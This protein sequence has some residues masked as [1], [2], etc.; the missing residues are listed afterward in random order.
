MN[1]Y[2]GTI[3]CSS[4]LYHHGIKGQKWGVRRFQNKDGS[5]IHRRA[6]ISR[7]L[8]KHGGKGEPSRYRRGAAVY[9][10]YN[11]LRNKEHE[12]LTKNSKK[13]RETEKEIE[14]L[15]NKWAYDDEEQRRI[16]DRKW[17]KELERDK[18]NEEFLKKAEKYATDTIIEKRGEVAISDLNH[19]QNVNAAAATTAVIL[20][21]IGMVAV[22]SRRR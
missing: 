22:A 3:S 13:Y 11:E 17:N 21:A 12:R 10:E 15:K 6:A 8:K 16:D 1:Y 18:M 5:P 2:I 19:F 20:A 9:K 14:D 7:S 4:E